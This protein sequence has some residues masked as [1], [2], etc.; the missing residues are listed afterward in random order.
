MDMLD[1]EKN[2][3]CLIIE[4]TLVR[5]DWKYNF[6]SLKIFK[7]LAHLYSIGL[8]DVYWMN[9]DDQG[10]DINAVEQLSMRF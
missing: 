8:W 4:I 7:V 5:F 2:F 9:F 6:E 3:N 10:G 1:S